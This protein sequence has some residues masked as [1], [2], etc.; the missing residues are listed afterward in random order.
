MRVVL[1]NKSIEVRAVWFEDNKVKM[2]DQRLI[3]QEFKVVDF[4][5][6]KGVAEAIRN[7]TVRGAPSIGAA[8]AY[9]I[10]LA[11]RQGA[12]IEEAAKI[13]KGTRPT[14]HDLFYAVDHMLRSLDL[15][16]DPVEAAD[17]YA[18]DVVDRCRLIGKFGEGLI[19]D[20][21][22]LMT[23]CNA[24]ALAT[25]DIGTALAPIRA[26]WTAGKHISV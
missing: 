26:A 15:G 21:D 12:D 24:G 14:A 1:G 11:A 25:V 7:M 20:E 5:D 23:H 4:S 8:A 6:Y 9:G 16:D 3:P 13:I 2:I 10:A 17:G 19:R 18:D 22:I